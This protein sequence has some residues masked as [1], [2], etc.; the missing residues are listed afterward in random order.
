MYRVCK[1]C[2]DWYGVVP[3]TRVASPSCADADLA[4]AFGWGAAA[5]ALRPAATG[6]AFAGL[7]LGLGLGVALIPGWR[8]LGISMASGPGSIERALGRDVGRPYSH[9]PLLNIK[10]DLRIL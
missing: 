6:L 8:L 9:N 4:V 2:Q 10:Y 1:R 3:N 7:A 5:L